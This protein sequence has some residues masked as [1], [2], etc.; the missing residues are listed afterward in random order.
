MHVGQLNH[1]DESYSLTKHSEQAEHLW[2]K[3]LPFVY[4]EYTGSY[5][6]ELSFH[7]IK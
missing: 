1:C 2:N 3:D 5:S 4:T 7:A 6:A